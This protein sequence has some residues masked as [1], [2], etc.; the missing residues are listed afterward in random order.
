M[1]TPEFRIANAALAGSIQLLRMLIGRGLIRPE[2]VD[3]FAMSINAVLENAADGVGSEPNEVSSRYARHIDP[4]LAE[5][6]QI[7]ARTYRP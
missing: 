1:F 6:R 2:D 3:D 5:L 4:I 7:A